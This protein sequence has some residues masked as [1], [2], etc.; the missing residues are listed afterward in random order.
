AQEFWTVKEVLAEV[1]DRRARER[2][3][4]LP[5]ELKTREPSDEAVA[6]VVRFAKKTGDLT[7]LSKPD[8]RI[9]ALT[10]MLHVEEHGVD[11][12]RVDPIKSHEALSAERAER[13]KQE[14]ETEKLKQAE[15]SS[16]TVGVEE[17][18][19]NEPVLDIKS[20]SIAKPGVSWAAALGGGTAVADGSTTSKTNTAEPHNPSER[21][22]AADP[23]EMWDDADFA[24]ELSQKKT[25]PPQA[26]EWPSLDAARLEAEQHDLEETRSFFL[27][28]EEALARKQQRAAKKAAKAKAKAEEEQLANAAAEA[29]LADADELSASAEA[30]RYGSRILGVSGVTVDSSAI[31]GDEGWVTPANLKQIDPAQCLRGAGALRP[32]SS[33][34]DD[35]PVP[36]PLSSVGCVTTDYAMQNVM[37]Q[38][39]LR[40]LTLEGRAVT[41][42]RRF[43]LKC[44]SC[45]ATTR[46]LDKKF[47]P[48]CGN[49]TLGR[50]SYSIGEDGVLRYHYKKNRKV[51]TRGKRYSIPK[52]AGGR[53]GDL[54][55]TEDQL[56]TGWWGQQA[57]KKNTAT[58]MFG[59]HVTEAFGLN[60]RSE[61]E[62]IRVGYG[63]QNPNAAKGRERRGKK[64]KRNTK[65]P[66]HL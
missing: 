64:K 59:E 30:P 3:G 37:L 43:V 20:L 45:G 39:Q 36:R 32:K 38:M 35:E 57:R 24:D 7:V 33:A 8:I 63:R 48:D 41:R 17:P 6:A 61:G 23:S 19:D 18:Q 65:R 10:Y 12:L 13:A 16:K 58:S 49:P 28:Q 15:P 14:Q 2:L 31:E 60:L 25:G 56:L 66:G 1:R 52:P 34:D 11:D 26:E 9:M 5:F 47:C 42:V 51:N 62:G 40:L 44:D 54:L 53:T 22:P 4:V 46:Q 55:L 27:E 50:L 21:Q 29:Q